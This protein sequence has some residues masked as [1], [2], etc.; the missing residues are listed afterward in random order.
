MCWS[1]S[2]RRENADT[3]EEV[4]AEPALQFT[5]VPFLFVIGKT[6]CG[7]AWIPPTRPEATYRGEPA[8]LN[9]ELRWP[10]A[11]G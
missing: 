7:V 8:S 1:R 11:A 3:C 6:Y 5:D 10:V 4:S 9:L 2:T